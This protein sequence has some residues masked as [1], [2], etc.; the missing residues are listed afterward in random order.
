[1]FEEIFGGGNKPKKSA[2]YQNLSNELKNRVEDKEIEGWEILEVEDE[3]V[4]MGKNKKGGILK[5][6]VLFFFTGWLT[7]GLGNV[8]YHEHK[9]RDMKKTVLRENKSDTDS[10]TVEHLESLKEMK[11]DGSISEQE[12]NELK[13]DIM[14]ETTWSKDE[15]TESKK[16]LSDIPREDMTDLE[17]VKAHRQR[18]QPAWVSLRSED[19]KHRKI[20]RGENSITME[21]SDGEKT[22][23]FLIQGNS[24]KVDSPEPEQKNGEKWV[25]E[26][27]SYLKENAT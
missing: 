10:S 12:F 11:D 2:T 7:A 27:K 5:H 4:V 25:K 24:V 15:N 23:E 16:D 6:G 17:R 14:G 20:E 13:D 3:R 1:M 22:G 8:A 18:S 19:Y 9:K 26:A 21:V